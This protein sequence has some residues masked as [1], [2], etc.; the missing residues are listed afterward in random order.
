[1]FTGIITHEGLFSGYRRARQE[2][3]IEAPGLTGKLGPGDS[4]SVNGVCLSLLGAEK[5]ELRFNLSLETTRR[6]TLGALKH[7]DRLNLE[8]PLALASPLGGH[9]VTGHV[10]AVGKILRTAERRPGRRITVSFPKGIRPF[11][12]PKG[13]VAVN[14]VSLTIAS[15]GPSSMDIEL[16]PLTLKGTNL[17]GLRAGASVNLEC[18]II[19]KYMYNWLVK[20]QRTG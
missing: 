11:L 20:G 19:G 10:D 7:H 12:I 4:V 16:V 18:D 17:G 15:L 14:G 5:G 6:T 9:L 13:S 1:M 2:L 8:L 3:L